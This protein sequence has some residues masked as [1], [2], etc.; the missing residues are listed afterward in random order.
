MRFRFHSF[1]LELTKPHQ[2]ISQTKQLH[3]LIAKTHLS[4]DPFFPTKL[5]RLYAINCDLPSARKLFDESPNRSVFLWNSIIRAYAQAYEFGDALFFFSCFLRSETRPD[6]F[7][8]ACVIRACSD[9]LDLDGLKIVHG[10][11][12]VSGLSL[13]S[14]C[15]SAFVN[16]YSRLSLVDQA[17]R[18]FYQ[19]EEPDLVLWNTMI[20]GYVHSGFW[21]EGLK[22][23]NS[24]LGQQKQPDG[25]T[26]VGLMSGVAGSG[27]LTVGQGL[28]VFCLKNGVDTSVHVGSAIVSM[29]TRCNCMSWAFAAFGSILMPDLVAWSALIGGYS[30]AGDHEKV[31][32]FLRKFLCEGRKADSVLISNLLSSAARSG[33]LVAG[34]GI[35]CYTLRHGFESNVM[36]S[37]IL[38]DMY[39]KC[40]I[41]GSG[42]HV[43]EM[44]EVKN[45]VSYNSLISGLGLNGLATRAYEVFDEMLERGIE[46]DSSTFSA[47]LSA[48]CHSRLVHAGR[49]TLKRMTEHF[50]LQPSTEHFIHMVKLLGAVG[51]LEEAYNFVLSLARPIDSGVWGALLSCCDIHGNSKLAKIIA[52]HLFQNEPE[53]AAYRVML[54]NVYASDQRWYDVERLRSEISEQRA[55]KLPGVSWIGS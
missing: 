43:F 24:M 17:S 5:V 33:N 7:S 3:A 41:V 14:I 13:D 51:E 54:S 47:L 39:F 12:I 8:F 30:Q 34:R 27:S 35:H 18:V 21:D 31:L 37:S 55:R 6:N 44:M 29:Y 15:G 38:I 9:N 45:V 26:L 16:G 32:F 40:G 19:M 20:S 2:K 46:P 25:Y 52:Q 50:R 42:I 11:T 48:C 36:V 1:L 53:K 23:F 28:H 10:A 22:L 49:D 4:A